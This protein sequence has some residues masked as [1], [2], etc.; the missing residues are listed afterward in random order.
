MSVFKNRAELLQG[1]RRPAWA[2]LAAMALMTMAWAMARPEPLAPGV[3][4]IYDTSPLPEDLL[5][6]PSPEP[7][8]TTSLEIPPPPATA[9]AEPEEEEPEEEPWLEYRIRRNDTM[10]RILDR[11]GADDEAKEFLLAQKMKS[12]RKLRR[13]DTVR[14]RLKSGRLAELQYKTSPEYYLR[15]GRDE[16]G[17]LWAS[18]DAPELISREEGRGGVIQEGQGLF[19]AA[20]NAGVDDGVIQSL[21]DL[22]ETRVDFY[23]G[24]WAGD[25]FRVVYDHM[26]DA[27]G[28]TVHAGRVKAFEFVNR[29]RVIRGAWSE[30]AKGYYDESGA[31]MKSAFLSAPLK[32]TRISSKFSGR[33]FHPVLKKWRAHRGVDYA[34]R[35]G[36][37]V[38]ATA[39]GVVRF[40][41]KKGGYGNLILL[42]HFKIYT[43][44]YGHLHKFAKGIRK[45]GRVQQGQVIGYVGSTGLSTGPHL[46]YEFRV[47]GVHRDPLAAGVPKQLPPL[48]G[49][50]LAQFKRE[51]VEVWAK[52]GGVAL[53]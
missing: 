38:R 17:A 26:T 2:C 36:T 49:D 53:L 11:I 13:G 6:A 40:V 7:P 45:G 22:L 31:A 52:L 51:T 48:S 42:N 5:P 39:D 46:H 34:A 4:P 12:Y 8:P 28:F 44:A 9:E 32:Y 19:I 23:R 16:A 14:F 15:A 47:R 10:A 3:S 29:G 41:G 30:S 24:V 27:D 18:E 1:S 43:T 33:R 35:R 20:D 21:I 37:P 25:S 50:A